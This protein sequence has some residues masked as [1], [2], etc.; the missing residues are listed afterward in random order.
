MFSV[1]FSI[2]WQAN[3]CFSWKDI[4][5]K[6]NP[7]FVWKHTWSFSRI[8]IWRLQIWLCISIILLSDFSCLC[9]FGL[10]LQILSASFC[11]LEDLLFILAYDLYV[12][13]LS[14]LTAW[15]R[16]LN[17]NAVSIMIGII[18]AVPVYYWL[19]FIILIHVVDIIY[20]SSSYVNGFMN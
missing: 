9:Q 3:S 18:G 10:L 15:L 6:N 1:W 13:A 5:M 16:F 12:W 2:R 4:K 14:V 7:L 20:V 19:K 17:C 8:I 11:F